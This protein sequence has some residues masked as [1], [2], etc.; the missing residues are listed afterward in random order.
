MSAL[1]LAIFDTA[2]GP[3]G[4]V[5]TSRGIAGVNLPEGS[6]EK[7]RARLKKRFPEAIETPPPAEIQKI[8]DE[9]IALI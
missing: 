8:V 4:I 5:W 9:V 1:S 7:T 2:L 6:E 3:C